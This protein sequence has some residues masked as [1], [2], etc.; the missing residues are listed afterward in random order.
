[1]RRSSSWVLAA[2]VVSL[3]LTACASTGVE[4]TDGEPIGPDGIT[5]GSIHFDAPESW[6]TFTA[7]TVAAEATDAADA[8]SLAPFMDRM[9]EMTGVDPDALLSDL[10]EAAFYAF[11]PDPPGEDPVG[12]LS[13]VESRTG[14]PSGQLVTEQLEDEVDGPDDVTPFLT[15]DGLLG[16]RVRYALPGEGTGRWYAVQI[17]VTAAG[18]TSIISIVSDRSER[19]ADLAGDIVAASLTRS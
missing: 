16:Q 8:A 4:V 18:V 7:D 13:L 10:D 15:S 6:L 1:M 9:A 17:H 19:D 5:T 11:S 12:F 2:G 14:S 3:L